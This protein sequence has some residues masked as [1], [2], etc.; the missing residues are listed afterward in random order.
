MTRNN[1]R[2]YAGVAV[3]VI[4]AASAGYGVARLSG[5]APAAAEEE[6]EHHEEGPSGAVAMPAQV[7]QASGIGLE[8]VRAGGLASEVL[9]QATVSAAPGGQALVTARAAGAVT[10]INVRLGDPVRAGQA[11]AVVESREAAQI[12]AERSAAVAKAT[13]AQRNLA[14]E[15]SLFE[16]RVS[17]RMDYEVAQAEAAAASAEARRALAAAG[18]ANVTSDGRGVVLASPISGRVTAMTAALGAYVTPE[19]ELFRVADPGRVQVEAALPA[20]EASRVQPGDRARVEMVDG[21][22]LEATVR[23]VTPG[24]DPE[25]RTATAVLDVGA[26]SLQPGLTARARIFP[27]MAATNTAIIVPDEAVQSVE[28]RDVVFVRTKEGFQARP[29][30]RGQTSAGRTEIVSG[31]AAGQQIATK[32]AFLL[33]A[34][35]GKGEGDEH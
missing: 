19:A 32:N 18:A 34:E 4:V 3:A 26:A 35:L 29:V 16:Q 31:L 21:R 9:A 17:P 10:R 23:S 7:I 30:V 14:R 13:L 1:N 24:L 28:G 27:K 2:L 33:K 15:K 8:T 12:A 22:V 25:S 11:L 5:P 20:T 6:A